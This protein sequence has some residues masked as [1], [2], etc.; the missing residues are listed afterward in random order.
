[1][2][3]SLLERLKENNIKPYHMPGHKRQKISPVLLFAEE[4]MKTQLQNFRKRL[5]VFLIGQTAKQKL[6]PPLKLN[7]FRKR[8]AI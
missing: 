5:K 8:K 6:I 3:K 2:S 1:M 7:L 4:I